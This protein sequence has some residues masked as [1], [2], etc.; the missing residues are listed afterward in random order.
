[1][2][3]FFVNNPPTL[4]P[5]QLKTIQDARIRYGTDDLVLILFPHRAAICCTRADA[6]KNPPSESLEAALR[7]EPQKRDRG[8]D[9]TVI[10][11]DLVSPTLYQA[12]GWRIGID[13]DVLT[14]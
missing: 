11:F 2:S 5:D 12:M 14:N 9:L 3:S 7:Q 10:V 1:M 8:F 13:V 6:I 4:T